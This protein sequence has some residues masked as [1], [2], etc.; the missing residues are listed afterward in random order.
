MI[1]SEEEFNTENVEKTGPELAR[2]TVN[3]WLDYK[4]VRQSTRDEYADIID[5]L[6]DAVQSGELVLSEDF[7]FTYKLSFPTGVDNQVTELTFKSRINDNELS[8]FI[9]GVKATDNR[10]MMWGYAAALTVT[11]RGFIKTLD[12]IDL[13]MVQIY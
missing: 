3:S 7:K 5:Y 1:V 12:S 10:N 4:K 6:C 9:K 11:S 13:Q 2:E 8:K